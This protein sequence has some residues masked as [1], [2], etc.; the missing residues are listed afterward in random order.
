MKELTPRQTQL[1]KSI[2]EEYTQTAEPVGSDVLEK[3]YNLGVSPATIRNEMAGLT[4]T[5]FLKQPHASA[6]RVPT[7][8]AIKLYIDQIMDERKLTVAQEVAAKDRVVSAKGD[9]DG[10]MHETT[11][12]LAEAT[13]SLAVAMTED[14]GVWHSG[15]ANIL[16]V[17]EF[18]NIDVTTQVLLLLEQGQRMHELFFDLP[19]WEDPVEVLF[20]ED[21]GW[22]NFEPVAVVACK[23][24]CPRGSGSLGVIGSA[25][26]DYPY[27]KPI[28]RYFGNLLTQVSENA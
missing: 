4:R 23:F 22:P 24:S 7:P 13:R 21:L 25:R 17:S 2:V 15:Y 6:G 5:G 28:V 20:G 27:I 26:L 9:F 18:Y 16:S 1:I 19:R 11:R 3:K 8:K 12:A 10:L 14:G